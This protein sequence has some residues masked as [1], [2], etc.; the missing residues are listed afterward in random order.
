MIEIVE[1]EN[2]DLNDTEYVIY[3]L[4]EGDGRPYGMIFPGV[5]NSATDEIVQGYLFIHSFQNDLLDELE[6]E[7]DDE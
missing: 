3:W 5:Q 2:I 1:I 7:M 4:Q 6:E